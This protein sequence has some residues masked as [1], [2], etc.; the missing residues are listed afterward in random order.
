MSG[1]NTI[2]K[3]NIKSFTN[4]KSD[5]GNI[6][7]E[8]IYEMDAYSDVELGYTASGQTNKKKNKR[9]TNKRQVK[10]KGKV[11]YLMT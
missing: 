2:K 10:K 8:N 11:F 3:E 9:Q 5:F 4:Q 1:Q 7:K 6:T